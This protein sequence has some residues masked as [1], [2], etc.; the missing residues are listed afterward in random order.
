MPKEHKLSHSKRNQTLLGMLM[1][2][3]GLIWLIPIYYMLISSFKPLK[4]VLFDISAFPKS[5]YVENFKIV[6]RDADFFAL[7]LN[8]VIISGVSL[9]FVAL[10]SSMAGWRLARKKSKRALLLLNLFTL[11][12]IIPFQGIMIPL[13]KTMKNF[14]L[15][16]S[17]YGII[18][19]YIAIGCSM[20]M[21]L[22]YG[23]VKAIPES[24]EE[25]AYIDGAGVYRTFFSIVLPLLKPMTG[26][27][28]ILQTIFF[29]NDF[30]LPLITLQ[31]N[32]LKT[33][34]LGV[35]AHFFGKYQNQWQLGMTAMLLA[36]LPMLILY[37]LMQ[38]QIVSG[39]T[40]G[41]VK[42]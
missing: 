23:A 4:N 38:R 10:F 40:K 2:L 8:S 41:A 36:S 22:Y 19:V 16:D 31:S 29:W 35:T 27:V 28:V 39:I 33:I 24:L 13:V 42:E 11:T 14:N 20:P 30:L 21:F 5:F 1:I 34:P 25:S 12:L 6:W 32:H 7:F 15:I 18:L 26:T 37:S 3:V 9:F 17:R